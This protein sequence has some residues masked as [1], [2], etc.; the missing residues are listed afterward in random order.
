MPETCY[1]QCNGMGFAFFN[2]QM[3][4]HGFSGDDLLRDPIAQFL[5]W[6]AEACAA[7]R[8]VYKKNDEKWNLYRLSP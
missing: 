5:R 2:L 1:F 8:F 7:D 6:Y 4:K 3:K